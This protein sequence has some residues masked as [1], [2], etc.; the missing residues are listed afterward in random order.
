MRGGSESEPA[1]TIYELSCT[2]SSGSLDERK[3]PER[4]CSGVRGMR[5]TGVSARRRAVERR[6]PFG[7]AERARAQGLYDVP[8]GVE[9]VDHAVVRERD[10]RIAVRKALHVTER[11][12]VLVPAARP[13][14]QGGGVQRV[15][16]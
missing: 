5:E 13:L 11:V 12:A 9:L 4:Q 14:L 15:R 8:R 6:A 7:I 10:E 16:K 2:L 3:L 1:F